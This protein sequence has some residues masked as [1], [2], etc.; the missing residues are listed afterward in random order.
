M[1]DLSRQLRC[2]KSTLYSHIPSKQLLGPI[3]SRLL[4]RKI[5]QHLT[6]T[7]AEKLGPTER[8]AEFVVISILHWQRTSTTFREQLASTAA[9]ARIYEAGLRHA[10]MYLEKVFAAGISEGTFRSV[11]PTFA[12]TAVVR[13]VADPGSR[14]LS[15]HDPVIASKRVETLLDFVIHSVLNT[16]SG[17]DTVNYWTRQ[18]T[19]LHCHSL[20]T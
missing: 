9:T 4:F 10:T 7:F 11:H 20:E 3:V 18:F 17:T 14:P 6:S 12:A 19:S 5:R 8:L 16:T 13:L 15:E 2:S 1:D